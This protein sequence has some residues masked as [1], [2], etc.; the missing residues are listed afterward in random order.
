LAE[1]AL[2]DVVVCPDDHWDLAQDGNS[3]NCPKC[4]RTFEVR[5][6]VPLLLPTYT[7]EV[8]ER[9]LKSY[10]KVAHDDLETP[11]EGNREVRHEQLLRF[12]GDLR[13]K[14]VLD[15]GS[16]DAQYL[17]ATDAKLKVALDLALP[18]LQAIPDDSGVLGV[19]ADAESLPVKPGLFDVIII[20]GVLEHLLEPEKLAARLQAICRPD[21]RVI[22]YVPWEEDLAPYRDLPWEFTHLRTFDEFRFSQLFYRFKIVKRAPT[23]PK[24]SDPILFK[25]GQRLPTPLYN[26]L[27]WGYFHRGLGTREYQARSRWI[28]ELPRRQKR[29]LRLYPP[30]FYQFELRLLEG[31]WEARTYD[32]LSAILKRFRRSR[33]SDVVEQDALGAGEKPAPEEQHADRDHDQG[34]D[35]PGGGDDAEHEE[36]LVSQHVVGEG[37]DRDHRL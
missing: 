26:I 34:H 35:L 11:L 33:R 6:G 5:R 1:V 29:L 36:L 28:A 18:Y 24:L 13:G 14:R 15:I 17:A 19:C 7:D 22:A 25:F 12:M 2:T 3:L 27:R 4:L 8:R 30:F 37:V 9:Y 23:W 21:T 32:R 20:A 31:S 10:E 16:S